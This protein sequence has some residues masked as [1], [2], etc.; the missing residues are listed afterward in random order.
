MIKTIW[1]LIPFPWKIIGA[2]FIVSAVV[3]WWQLH[4]Y[5]QRQIGARK[6]INKIEGQTNDATDDLVKKADDY[7]TAY[8]RCRAKGL[9]F[10]Y[11]TSRCSR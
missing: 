9:Q 6:A 11:T 4:N 8:Q 2:A 10:D 3:G 7:D 1:A 5:Q